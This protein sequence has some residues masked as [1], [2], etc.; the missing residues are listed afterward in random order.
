MGGEALSASI[1]RLLFSETRYMRWKAVGCPL[2]ERL[3]TEDLITSQRLARSHPPSWAT[4]LTDGFHRYNIP[5][6]LGQSD[7]CR[8]IL[9]DNPREYEFG[10]LDSLDVAKEY[11]RLLAEETPSFKRFVQVR[12]LA[13]EGIEDHTFV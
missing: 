11:A 2:F 6:Y 7:D 3:L 9:K 13:V 12:I 1:Q 4:D 10:C 5:R 8:Q